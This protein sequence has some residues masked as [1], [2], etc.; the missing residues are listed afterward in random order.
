MRI[1][2][3]SNLAAAGLIAAGAALSASWAVAG[4]TV[5]ITV[6]HPYGKI[7]RPIHQKIIKEFNKTHPNVKVRLEALGHSGKLIT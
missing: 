2:K 1:A 5:E 4:E 6:A 3:L 7:F